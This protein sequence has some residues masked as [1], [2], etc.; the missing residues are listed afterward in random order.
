MGLLDSVLGG[1]LGSLGGQQGGA[2]GE[3]GGNAALI[4]AVVGMLANGSAQGGLG[5][6]LE[7]FQQSGLGDVAASWVGTGQNQPVSADQISNVLGGDA[8]GGMARQL[9]LNPGDL[10]GQL[11]QILPQVV[12]QLTPNGQAPQGGLGDLSSILGQL[13]RR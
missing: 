6:L 2:A 10:A 13:M 11:S 8:I 4:S 3:G 12:D 1:V 9:G 5:G 7:K